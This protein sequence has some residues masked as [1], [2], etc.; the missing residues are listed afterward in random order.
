[1]AL[2]PS[3]T[4]RQ[5]FAGSVG[6]KRNEFDH[7]RKRE[8]FVWRAGVALPGKEPDTRQDT[9]SW[10]SREGLIRHI[11]AGFGFLLDTG[12]ELFQ[13]HSSQILARAKTDRDLALR[14][15]AL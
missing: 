8:P 9:G 5:H 10:R 4:A 14:R 11:L 12:G 2:S 15:L 7:G 6:A 1:M 13:G 3:I